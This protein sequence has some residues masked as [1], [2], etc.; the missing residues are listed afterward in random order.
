MQMAPNPT[1]SH[2][3]RPAGLLGRLRCGELGTW[4]TLAFSVALGLLIGGAAWAGGQP[5]LGLFAVALLTAVGLVFV[6]GRRSESIRMMAGE[7]ADERWR[8]INLRATAFTGNV[9]ILAVIGAFLWEIA[10]GRS[11]QP[12]APLGAIAGISYLVAV[13]WLRWRS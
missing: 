11:G 5:G 10:H 1:D 13:I 4:G 6:L 2:D 3:P 7:R 8:L 9:L 12:F